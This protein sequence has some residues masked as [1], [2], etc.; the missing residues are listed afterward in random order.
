M[1]CYFDKYEFIKSKMIK[2]F[3][4]YE[5]RFTKSFFKRINIM[6]EYEITILP[7]LENLKITCKRFLKFLKL[8]LNIENIM[9][10]SPEFFLTKFLI[11][12]FEFYLYVIDEFSGEIFF[13]GKLKINESIASFKQILNEGKLKTTYGVN[14]LR[15][16]VFNSYEE[17]IMM[18]KENDLPHQTNINEA[19]MERINKD[20]NLV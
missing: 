19:E 9:Y 5:N 11:P 12:Y 15:L 20:Y 10:K 2:K 14:K 7:E 17:M 4:S 8:T 18:Q 6:L 3:P 16:E 13:A 1:Y